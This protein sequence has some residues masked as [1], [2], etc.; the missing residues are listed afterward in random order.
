MLIETAGRAEVSAATVKAMYEE[1]PYPSPIA[2]E[3]VIDDV[4]NGLYSLFGENPLAGWRILD[5]GCGTGHRLMGVARAYPDAQI[6]GLDMT[7]ASLDVA[8]A[9]AR[10]H[11]IHNVQFQQGDL[12]N[13]GLAGRFDLVI[14]T[15]VI[16]CLEDAQQGLRNLASLLAPE[17]LLFVWLYHAVGEHQ[18]MMDRELLHLMW[19]ANEGLQRGV[20]TMQDLGL[21]LEV[22]QYGSSSAQSSQEVS[23]LNIDVDA[24]IHPIVRVYNFGE[25]IDMFRNCEQLGWAS[26]LSANLDGVSKLVDLGEAETTDLRFMCQTVEQLFDTESLRKRF[27]QLSPLAKLRVMELKMKPTGFTIIGGPAGSFKKLGPRVAASSITF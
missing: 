13:H 4:A 25:A 22:K 7:T 9:L 11:D 17:G 8:R 6:T 26:I 14:C 16:V 18:R 23:Q 1:Y 24:Y 2:G 21:H 27:R 3:S 19:N 15:G 20:Q 12:L 10:K 5:A